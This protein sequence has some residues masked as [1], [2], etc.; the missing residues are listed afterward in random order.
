LPSAEIVDLR[1]LLVAGT[2]RLDVAPVVRIRWRCLVLS[3]DVSVYP[4][5]VMMLG[6]GLVAHGLSLVV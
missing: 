1:Q 3:S 4:L 5:T 6:L 2:S